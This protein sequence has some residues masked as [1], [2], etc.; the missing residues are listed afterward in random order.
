LLEPHRNEQNRDTRL[1][2]QKQKAPKPEL[3]GLGA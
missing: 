3:S 2:R 1:G